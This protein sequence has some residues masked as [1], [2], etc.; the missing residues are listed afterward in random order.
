MCEWHLVWPI[1]KLV[2]QWV[3]GSSCVAAVIHQVHA[4]RILCLVPTDYIED[5]I[6]LVG[7]KLRCSMHYRVPHQ[8]HD[9]ERFSSPYRIHGRDNVQMLFQYR[10]NQLH[11]SNTLNLGCSSS[12]VSTEMTC[13]FVRFTK[14]TGERNAE[15]RVGRKERGKIDIKLSACVSV[16]VVLGMLKLR[17]MLR[18]GWRFAAVAA[19]WASVA[20]FTAAFIAILLRA[21]NPRGG[22]RTVLFIPFL[23]VWAMLLSFKSSFDLERTNQYNRSKYRSVPPLAM[24]TLFHENCTKTT[25][26][27]KDIKIFG[28]FCFQTE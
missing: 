17:L 18:G 20:V 3:C 5:P 9:T 6:H 7:N 2:C 13:W 16:C 4:N 12:C 15:E 27:S 21:A 8:T 10:Y 25:R 28:N 22:A 23:F 1:R 19:A 26:P 11:D 14:K 24:T